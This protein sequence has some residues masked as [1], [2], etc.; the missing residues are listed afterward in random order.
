MKKVVVQVSRL[1]EDQ[2][3]NVVWDPVLRKYVRWV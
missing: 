2:P 3:A 1:P